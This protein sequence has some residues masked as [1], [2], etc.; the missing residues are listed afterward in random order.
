MSSDEEPQSLDVVEEEKERSKWGEKEPKIDL[1]TFLL[2]Q[3]QIEIVCKCQSQ[4]KDIFYK[5]LDPVSSS[6][7]DEESKIHLLPPFHDH[8][9]NKYIF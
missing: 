2:D 5:N 3:N 4:G 8:C 7:N 1:S 6:E 9:P